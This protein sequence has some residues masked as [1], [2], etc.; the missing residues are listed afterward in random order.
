MKRG[1]VVVAAAPGDFGKPRP[2]LVV[3]SNFFNPTHSSV[4]ICPFTPHLIGAPLF[5]VAIDKFAALKRE[6][7]GKLIGH[8][9]A[10]QMSRVSDALRMWL[11]LGNP[12]L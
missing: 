1:D 12:E 7:I 11:E 8:L 3:Q 9:S 5:R 4:V 6:R 10:S 2:A